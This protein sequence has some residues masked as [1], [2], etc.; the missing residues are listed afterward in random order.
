MQTFWISTGWLN[1]GV[2]HMIGCQAFLSGYGKIQKHLKPAAKNIFFRFVY[3]FDPSALIK[4]FSR[5]REKRGKNIEKFHGKHGS[6]LVKLPRG[7]RSS[8]SKGNFGFLLPS[9]TTLCTSG[10][11]SGFASST[12]SNLGDEKSER[13]I[14]FSRRSM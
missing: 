1:S 10:F 13:K 3:L 2:G 9:N 7:A 11:L 12:S 14:R 8:S 4:Q 6:S 5:N